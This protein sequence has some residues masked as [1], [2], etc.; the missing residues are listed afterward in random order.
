MSCMMFSSMCSVIKIIVFVLWLPIVILFYALARCFPKS[1][2]YASIYFV[3]AIMLRIVGIRLKIKGDLFKDDS[4]IYLANHS[5]YIDL[6]IMCSLLPAVCVSKHEVKRWPFFGLIARLGNAI[7]I[8][9]EVRDTRA[10]V[11]KIVEVLRQSRSILIFPEGTTS[12]G[13]KILPFKSSFLKVVEEGICDTEIMV[14]PI[15][16]FYSRMNGRPIALHERGI[17]AWYGDDT[18]V[19]HMWNL[20]K[21][22]SSVV[23]V[24]YHPVIEASKIA[25][26][27]RVSQMCHK[28]I[29]DS[30]S[31]SLDRDC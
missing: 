4:V 1:V 26:R 24:E 6:V 29:S 16:I 22:K 19:A 10:N 15:T 30:F 31:A 18:L 20:F 13:T 9:R 14:Q 25:D 27:K 3:L 7:F 21:V 5:S 11:T 2:G 28:V 12:D 17:F 8:V 23:E